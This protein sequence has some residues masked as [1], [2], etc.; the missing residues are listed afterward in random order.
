MQTS[1]DT[2]APTQQA[3]EE[4][5]RR[6]W[7]LF[8][9]LGITLSLL[10]G[11]TFAASIS[12]NGDADIEFG[13]GDQEVTT[14][15]TTAE[16]NLTSAYDGDSF[17]VSRVTLTIPAAC[18]GRWI[19]IGLWD[20]TSILDYLV[21]HATAPTDLASSAT[22]TLDSLGGSCSGPTQCGPAVGTN[23]GLGAGVD[24][25][26]VDNFTVET[27]VGEPS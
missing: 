24:A 5:R 1:P 21:F 15:A 8:A 20:G 9:A 2:D 18:A 19:R 14:C 4:K 10:I 6:R 7:P 27:S 23:Y 13:Q 17:N 22:I 3:P 26:A 11:A 12:I 16:P 25:S